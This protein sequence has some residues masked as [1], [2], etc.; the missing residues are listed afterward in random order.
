MVKLRLKRMGRR[1]RMFFRVCAIDSRNQ[2]DG[3][4]I[5]EIGFYDPMEQSPDRSVRIDPERA[6]YWLSQGAQPTQTVRHLL[7]HQGIS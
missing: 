3:D 5:E 4:A 2:R 1:N 6:K 7:K